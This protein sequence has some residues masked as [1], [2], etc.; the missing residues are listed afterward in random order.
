MTLAIFGILCISN[1]QT[2]SIN[3]IIYEKIDSKWYQLYNGDQYEI[4]ESSSSTRNWVAWQH[5]LV[6]PL[7]GRSFKEIFLH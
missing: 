3:G 6:E 7:Q 1:A 2:K 4:D 5:R